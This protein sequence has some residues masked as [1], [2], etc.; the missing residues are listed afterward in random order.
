MGAN[1]F[2]TQ[3]LYIFP[4]HRRGKPESNCLCPWAASAGNAQRIVGKQNPG[5]DRGPTHQVSAQMSFLPGHP[6][7]PYISQGLLIR[8]FHT[9]FLFLSLLPTR[10]SVLSASPSPQIHSPLCM[11][12]LMGCYPQMKPVRAHYNCLSSW[13][14]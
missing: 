13:S 4:L 5:Q 3:G 9:V 7:L 14:K 10:P 8:C 1:G 11:L 12:F 6:P 2:S